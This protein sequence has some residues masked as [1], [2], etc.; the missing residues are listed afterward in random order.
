MANIDEIST[1]RLPGYTPVTTKTTEESSS[2]GED[3][4]MQLLLAQLRYQTPSDPMDSDQILSQMAQLNSLQELQKINTFLESFTESSS[5]L[6]ATGLIGKSI[7]YQVSEDDTTTAEGVVQGVS[8]S[9]SEIMLDLGE[10][11][12]AWDSVLSVKAAE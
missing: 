4:F 5:F 12:V 11:E 8:L 2:L 3:S 1:E 10:K 6:S 9:G 7:T